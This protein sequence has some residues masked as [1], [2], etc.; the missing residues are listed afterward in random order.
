M[1]D[2]FAQDGSVSP[3]GAAAP[4]LSGL[5]IPAID[6]PMQ[7]GLNVVTPW[8]GGNVSMRT[9]YDGENVAGASPQTEAFNASIMSLIPTGDTINLHFDGGMG[10][11]GPMGPPGPPGIPTIVSRIPLSTAIDAP[12][13]VMDDGTTPATPTGLTATPMIQ[14]VLLE[15]TANSEPDM[16]HYEVWRHTADVSG[17][18]SKIADTYQTLMVDGGRTGGTKLYYWIKAVDHLGNT[19]AFST[20]DNATPTDV[21]SGDL[22]STLT[23]AAS[24]IL[25]D[26]T[27][28][29]SNWRHGTDATKIDGGDIYAGTVTA[30]QIAAGTITADEISANT[31]TYDELRKV[32]GTE[33]VDTGCM[34]DAS[35]AISQSSSTDGNVT[36]TGSWTT[37]QTISNFPSAGGAIQ[38]SAQ[39]LI[40]IPGSPSFEYGIWESSNEVWVSGIVD[41]N[42][43]GTYGYTFN[44]I[45]TPGSGN[46]TF[47]LKAKANTGGT[48]TAS[49]RV[50]YCEE[51]QK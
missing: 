2:V 47:Y 1:A 14:A 16:D 19:S 35:A 4:L 39:F 51:T 33:A 23:L 5:Y 12:L 43:T 9:G 41:P 32:S 26:G 42:T 36:V 18:A 30:S 37:I 21:E 27:T 17:D 34:R 25:I 6:L 8:G 48:Y 22:D 3:V 7:N 49:K 11:P 50:L 31:I 44:V 29:L 15:W 20:G 13:R 10:I 24:K 38:I 45:D 28:Y 46:R 40:A